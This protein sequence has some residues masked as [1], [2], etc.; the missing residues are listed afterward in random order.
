MKAI[1]AILSTILVISIIVVIAGII[2]PWALNLA[3]NQANS[4]GQNANSQI[5]CQ[6]TS[7]DFDSSFGSNG[8]EWDFSG[9]SDW[10]RA[11]IINTGT[12]NLYGFSFQVYIQGTGYKSF[13]AKEQSD[14]DNSLKPSESIVIEA[15]ITEN[16]A[17]QLTEVQVLN[18]VCKGFS[19]KQE[20]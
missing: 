11:K 13:P 9:G 14:A 3:R 16:L 10:L 17:G 7:Y 5:T 12:I 15:N 20:L 6:S 8:V 1:D 19:L 4:T 2:G 18:S